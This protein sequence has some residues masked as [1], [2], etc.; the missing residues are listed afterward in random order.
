[1]AMTRDT[2]RRDDGVDSTNLNGA[3]HNAPEC[4]DMATGQAELEGQK[5]GLEV[6]HLCVLTVTGGEKGRRE[7]SKRNGGDGREGIIF[8][9]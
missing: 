2:T 9:S 4:V 8:F 3:A 5:D 7:E 6:P 1:M